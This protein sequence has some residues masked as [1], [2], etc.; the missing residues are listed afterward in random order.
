M[1]PLLERLEQD[2]VLRKFSPATRR[3]Y[4]LY[5]RLF[6]LSLSKPIDDIHEPDIRAFLCNQIQQ[7]QRSH[8]SYRQLFA[9]IKFLFTVTL[10]R[11]TEVVRVPFPRKRPQP[12]PSILSRQELV[13]LFQAFTSSR[14]RALFM[15]CY[16]AGLRINEACHLQVSDIDSKQNIIHV[17][18]AKGGGERV[19]LLSPRLLLELR[20]YWLL[21]RPQ[22]WL[23]P[24]RVPTKPVSTDSA[25]KALVQAAL[26]AG[27]TRP[28][29]PHTLRHCFAT[30]LLEAKTELV[31]I[32][33]LLGHG[34]IRTTTRYTRVSTHLL[35]AITSPL[36]LLPVPTT[37]QPLPAKTEG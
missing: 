4:L 8:E 31:V 37:T 12:L 11:P 15:T 32:Q 25:R 29:T 10:G 20:Q 33:S 2:L 3:N 34:S 36:D 27:L 24:A 30:H 17:R 14:F 28:C 13:E 21:E 1:Q 16:A 18:H 35:Q 7:H 5:A 9:V 23:F 26:D 22:T 6:L 19:T